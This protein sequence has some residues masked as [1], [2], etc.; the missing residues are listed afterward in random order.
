MTREKLTAIINALI[1]M[2]NDATDETALETVDLY[3]EWKPDT[4]YTVDGLRY[5]YNDHLYKIRQAHRSQAQYTPDI[6][7]AL[8]EL[9]AVGHSG[10]IDDPIPFGT[11]VLRADVLLVDARHHQ[12]LIAGDCDIR[13]SLDGVERT[14]LGAVSAGGSAGI[15]I[16]LH[17]VPPLNFAC[18]AI[19]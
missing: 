6:V 12:N 17:I 18:N 19:F 14:R 3:P 5:L 9:V 7:P 11:A 13:G 10:T 16:Q 1:K 15:H 2:R 8:Y 4:D